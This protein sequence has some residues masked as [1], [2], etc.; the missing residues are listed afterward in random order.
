M[1]LATSGFLMLTFV[2]LHLGGNLLA[3]AGS[4]TFDAYSRSLRELGSPLVGA[5]VLLT[6]ARVGLATALVAH[7]GAHA[8]ITLHSL[9][10]YLVGASPTMAD[11]RGPNSVEGAH[12]LVG[13]WSGMNSLHLIRP[14]TE[15]LARALAPAI[16]L[17]TAL[18]LA[19]VPVAVLLG[20]LN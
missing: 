15:H 9:R 8:W 4:A 12:L 10:E 18:G 5:G 3:F 19:A 14:R 17:G 7:L 11:G 20:T 13:V 1:V 6:L 16:A 2:V